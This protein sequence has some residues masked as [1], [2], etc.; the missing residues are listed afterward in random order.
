M[1]ISYIYTANDTPNGETFRCYHDHPRVIV[2]NTDPPKFN[3]DVAPW[4]NSAWKTILSFLGRYNFSR[5]YLQLLRVYKWFYLAPSHYWLVLSREWGNESTS[6]PY[7]SLFP[8]SLLRA[9]QITLVFQIPVEVMMSLLDNLF[10]DQVI[11]LQVFWKP[12]MLMSLQ[13]FLLK[14]N[15]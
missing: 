10:G 6:K 13:C 7:I 5:A 3:I 2:D 4:K 14:K 11:P 1:N 15:T 8:H 9:A 12:G